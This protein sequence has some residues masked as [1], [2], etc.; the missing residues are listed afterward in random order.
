MS[1]GDLARTRTVAQAPARRRKRTLA[2]F[3]IGD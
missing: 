1:E 2:E 3:V